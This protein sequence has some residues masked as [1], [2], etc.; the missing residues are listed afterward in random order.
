MSPV[1]W[2]EMT[3]ESQVCRDRGP[4]KF[5]SPNCS[6]CGRPVELET[7]K[8]DE[9]GKAVHEECYV[10]KV[11]RRTPNLFP[12]CLTGATRR[13]IPHAKEPS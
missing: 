6:V 1:L 9:F 4:K 13:Y 7:S 10:L 11:R 5:V 3:K 12:L 8:A 2:L